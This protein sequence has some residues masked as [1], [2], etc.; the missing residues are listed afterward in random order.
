MKHKFKH[1]FILTL[2]ILLVSTT[3]VFAQSS[4]PPI[5]EEKVIEDSRTLMPKGNGDL[6]D[7]VSDNQNLQFITVTARDGN[8]FYLIIDRGAENENVYF[9]NTVDES[10]LIS[11]IG[12]KAVK[13]KIETP[14]QGEISNTPDK[15]N[16][17]NS[18]GKEQTAER[19]EKETNSLFWVFL[20]LIFAAVSGAG[21]YFKVIL[22]KKKLE[23]ADDITDF[24]FT[25]EAEESTIEDYWLADA[26]DDTGKSQ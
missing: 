21:Y 2:T 6:L 23:Q 4:E 9:L 18:E 16:L 1:L 5:S 11:L 3:G 25:D 24:E 15:E 10:D 12:E 17:S 14:S 26:A 8:V 19:L 7:N 13:G 22:P 20:L